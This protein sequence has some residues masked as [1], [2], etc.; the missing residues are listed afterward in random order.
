MKAPLSW[1]RDGS[2]IAYL[3]GS[4]PDYTGYNMTRSP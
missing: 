2:E 1:S 4:K 3:Q